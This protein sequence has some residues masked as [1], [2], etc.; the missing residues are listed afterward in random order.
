MRGVGGQRRPGGADGAG[1]GPPP[2]L[3]GPQQAGPRGPA[4]GPGPGG[5]RLRPGGQ[6]PALCPDIKERDIY[7][8]TEN[9]VCFLTETLEVNFYTVY[10]HFL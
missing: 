8:K 3:P 6:V 9:L 10:I 2:L 1:E 7:I 5:T 4:A